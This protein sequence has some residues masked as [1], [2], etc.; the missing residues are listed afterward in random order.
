VRHVASAEERE[1]EQAFE[2]APLPAIEAKLRIDGL[3]VTTLSAQVIIDSGSTFNLISR[4]LAI[5]LQSRQKEKWDEKRSRVP[6]PDIRTANGMIMRA[7]QCLWLQVEYQDSHV[8]EALPFFVFEELPLA[9]IIGHETSE[10]WKA[11]LSWKHKTFSFTPQGSSEVTIPW[12]PRQGKHWRGSVNLLAK[13]DYVVPPGSQKKIFLAIE[14]GAL[15]DQGIRGE[16]GLITQQG[17]PRQYDVPLAVEDKK[18]T[19]MQVRNLNG[20]PVH[21]KKGEIVALFH[22]RQGYDIVE[23]P[24]LDPTREDILKEKQQLLAQKENA[25]RKKKEMDKI[26]ERE[27]AEGYVRLVQ[28]QERVNQPQQANK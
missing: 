25:S 9:A 12:T 26:W 17:Y 18:P 27:L 4:T 8:T 20:K 10:Q 23:A 6:L 13:Q 15:S 16:G 2:D 24:G 28:P 19:W 5:Q 1:Q 21:I 22:P 7:S 3:P 11:M 14:R